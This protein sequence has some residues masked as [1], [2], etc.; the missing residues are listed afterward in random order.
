MCARQI[1]LHITTTTKNFLRFSI[2]FRFLFGIHELSEMNAPT[3]MMLI[4]TIV[5]SRFEC[6]RFENNWNS[7]KRYACGW[8]RFRGFGSDSDGVGADNSM[9][10]NNDIHPFNDLFRLR[11]FPKSARIISIVHNLLGARATAFKC[12]WLIL[13]SVCGI[14]IY[15]LSNPKLAP[16]FKLSVENRSAWTHT[17]FPMVYIFWSFY[18]DPHPSTN[19]FK[20]NTSETRVSATDSTAKPNA[21]QFTHNDEQMRQ[22]AP[23]S[24]KKAISPSHNV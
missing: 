21:K 10:K 22:Q 24:C 6:L 12:T 19:F 1:H 17:H 14:C 13:V 23:N 3:A 18:Q 9:R 20:A 15:L 16:N 2:S 7:L 4:K 11:N 8:V 5:V